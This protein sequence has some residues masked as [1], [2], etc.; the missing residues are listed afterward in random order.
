MIRNGWRLGVVGAAA[1]ASAA[2]AQ[3]ALPSRQEV[4]PPTPD[5]QQEQPSP[6]AIDSRRAIADVPCP[7]ERSPLRLTLT[8]LAFARPDGGALPPAIATLLADLPVPAGDQPIRVVCDLRDRAN[9]ALQRAG[10]VASVQIPAQEIGGV[11]RLQVVTAHI[12]EV[13]VRGDAGPYRDVLR[14]RIARLQSLDPLNEHEAERLLLLAGDIPGLEVQLS[15]RPAGGEQGA[16]IGELSVQYRRF[17]LLANAQ[18][19]NSR[20]LGRE[21]L[22]ARGELYGLTG[23][24][25]VTYL[26]ASAT[27]DF[28]EQI[29]AQAGH[30]MGLDAAG[31]TAG[32]RFTYAWSRPD[33]GALD[34]RTDTL[35]A[36]LDLQR[37][38]LRSLSAN[39]RVRGGFDFVNQISTVRTGDISTRLT[40]DKLRVV[41]VGVDGDYRVLRSDGGTRLSL[42][43]SIEVRKGLDILGS[44]E[45]GF[46][47]GVLTSRIDGNSRA[48]VVRGVG[49]AVVG[50]TR[51]FSLAGETQAQWSDTPLLNYEQLSIG[52]LTIGRGYDPGSNSGD[53][54]IGGHGELRADLPL[55]S[56]LAHAGTGLQLFGFYDHV[57][58][59]NLG[60]NVLEPSRT[61]RSYGGGA[62]VSLPRRLVLE[63]SY[64][65]PRDRVLPLDERRP[66]DRVLVSLTAQLRGRA[67]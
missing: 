56:G 26:G 32:A 43:G 53:R 39:L 40:A 60:A 29:I 67:R 59:R 14:R 48:F 15:L 47:G 22:Y 8:G 62:R 30:I 23:H 36:G 21:T 45:R 10:W 2:G 27:T 4:T 25:D 49:D 17:S 50:L 41:F 9:A 52:N 61:L 51:V 19:Y 63:V 28:H 33:L 34:F 66:P 13:R 58:L 18:N 16:V 55:L 6:V 37:P 57:F 54:V 65:H 35:I 7:F 31:T 12:V 64:A 38:L 20:L 44:S 46:V 11:L 5:V 3:V 42:S 1:L 24:S